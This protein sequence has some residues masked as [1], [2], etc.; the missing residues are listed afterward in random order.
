MDIGGSIKHKI[1]L[2]QPNP[3]KESFIGV[4]SARFSAQ[5]VIVSTRQPATH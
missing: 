4:V 2:M 1:E 5:A 3:S